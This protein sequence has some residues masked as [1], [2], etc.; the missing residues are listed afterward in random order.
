MNFKEII[1]TRPDLVEMAKRE[2]K[3]KQDVADLAAKNGINFTPAELDEA[4]AYLS[5][6]L[7]DDMLMTVTGGGSDKNAAPQKEAKVKD[8]IT[9]DA[10]PF[11]ES[12]V[13]TI[14]GQKYI[15]YVVSK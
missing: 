4:Y 8:S 12:N 10:I 15:Q 14:G 7:T 9:I 13:V 5:D 11:D 3:S 6:T 1:A 2:C